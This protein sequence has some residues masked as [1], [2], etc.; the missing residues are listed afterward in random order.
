VAWPNQERHVAEKDASGG[1]EERRK[2]RQERLAAELRANLRKR[3]GRAKAG[4]PASP[5]AGHDTKKPG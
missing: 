4:A 5:G 2:Q 3:R 1:A